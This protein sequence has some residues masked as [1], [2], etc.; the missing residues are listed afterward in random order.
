MSTPESLVKVRLN[1]NNLKATATIE[2]DHS[3][4]TP[5]YILKKARE[6]ADDPDNLSI[7]TKVKNY[8]N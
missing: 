2:L 8:F 6:E 4:E 7:Q 3:A 5:K 1:I